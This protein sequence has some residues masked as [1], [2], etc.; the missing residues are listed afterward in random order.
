MEVDGT[1]LTVFGL[2]IGIVSGVL[3]TRHYYLKNLKKDLE[4]YFHYLVSV[5]D[6]IDES[7]MERIEITLDGTKTDN[8]YVLQFVVS[9]QGTR[10]ITDPI[11]PLSIAFPSH[12]NIINAEIVH[13]SPKDREVNISVEP[14]EGNCQKIVFNH[15]VLNH[16]EGFIVRVHYQGLFIPS[17][18]KF[19]IVDEDLP[20]SIRPIGWGNS[21]H[22]ITPPVNWLKMLVW[23][24]IAFT[25]GSII[26][27][28]INYALPSSV[29]MQY[30]WESINV[31]LDIAMIVSA[32]VAG[33][34]LA[35]IGIVQIVMSQDERPFFNRGCR[36]DIPTEFEKPE[37]IESDI[38][39]NIPQSHGPGT[40]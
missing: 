31:V 10:S 15:Q 7:I 22:G 26:I 4:V 20:P 40:S 3:I 35:G 6:N 17:E 29:H 14:A 11:Q 21:S 39:G 2:I 37:W 18:A 27:L 12:I 34:I 13:I 9:N 30:P 33:F 16:E 28:A 23:A 19:S 5:F 1:V 24:I 8:I 25:G 38:F 32:I 36:F